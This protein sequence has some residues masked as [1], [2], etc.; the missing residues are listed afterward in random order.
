MKRAGGRV[1]LGLLL[2]TAA[3][4]ADVAGCSVQKGLYESWLTKR[5]SAHRGLK[6]A[7]LR[8]SAA[9]DPEKQQSIG[10]EYQA[11]FQCLSDLA[12]QP[13]DK[14]LRSSCDEASGDRVGSVVC[15]SVLYVKTGRT[16]SKEFLDALP[17]NRKSAEMIWDLETIAGAGQEHVRTPAVFLPNG[18]A[19][20]LIDEL[21][22]LVL[23]GKETAA[24]K[25]FNISALAADAGARHMD[26]QIK[27]LM[28]ES[29]SVVVKEWAVLRQYQPKLKKLL[30]EMTA[31]LPRAELLKM[32][33]DLAGFCTKD[34]LDCPEILKVFGRP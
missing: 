21:F 14:A 4:G 23:D 17:A 31:S 10:E 5:S 1:I 7:L 29:P 22:L 20:K 9:S 32:R 11:F 24:A 13:D 34:N 28:R 12:G 3:A 8:T 2:A 27:I 33:Q 25:Y 26:E 30:S 19:Y 18:P 6:D 16:G 15:Q